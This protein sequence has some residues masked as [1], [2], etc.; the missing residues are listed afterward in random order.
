MAFSPAT[1][2]V[3]ENVYWFVCTLI[4]GAIVY[5]IWKQ[6]KQVEAVLIL[7]IGAA[8]IFYYWIKW[9]K[10]KNKDEDWPPVINPCPDYLILVSPDSTGAPVAVCMDFVGVTTQPNVF[11]KT[12]QDQIPQFADAD[13]DQ[14]AFTVPKA[15]PQDSPEDYNKKVCLQVQAKGLS[16]AGVCE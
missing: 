4:L 1:K 7:I 2:K 16:W 14:F 12:K 6:V 8:A 10:I 3:L 9:F 5:V 11:K 13:F 15:G